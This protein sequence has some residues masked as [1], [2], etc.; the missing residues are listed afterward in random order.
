M[1]RTSNNQESC[2]INNCLPDELFTNCL[3]HQQVDHKGSEN[4]LLER[5]NSFTEEDIRGKEPVKPRSK[6]TVNKI[7]KLCK[8]QR[9]KPQI[10]LDISTKQF[11]QNI[12]NEKQ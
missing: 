12:K 4:E 10:Q 8:I 1:A 3:L 9:I 11:K 7:I 2:L 5:S 6:I